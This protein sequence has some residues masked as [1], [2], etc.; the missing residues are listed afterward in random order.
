MSCELLTISRVGVSVRGDSV[1]SGEL[2]LK[3][4]ISRGM[5]TSL[6]G[7]QRGDVRGTEVKKEREQVD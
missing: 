3:T 1:C 4:P 7:E 5:S 2:Q 6:R